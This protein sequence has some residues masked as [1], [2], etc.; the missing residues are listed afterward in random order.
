M[1]RV[2]G[3]RAD[4]VPGS[5]TKSMIGHPQGASGAAGVVAAAL[6]LST[7]V[8]PPT[9]NVHDQDPDCDLDFI[10]N[11]A[12]RGARRGGALQLSRV[13]IEEQRARARASLGLHRSS[14]RS[15]A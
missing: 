8:L 11:D 15:D 14:Y 3:A 4:R 7:G 5:S 1:R 6:A 13:R 10:P 2:F 9:I 12:R